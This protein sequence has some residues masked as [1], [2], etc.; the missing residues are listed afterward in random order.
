MT[1]E[2][3]LTAVYAML[4]QS[5]VTA[6]RYDPRGAFVLL[7]SIADGLGEAAP[8]IIDAVSHIH[9]VAAL[10]GCE[11]ASRDARRSMAR[12]VDVLEQRLEAVAS[13]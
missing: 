4:G 12:L 7:I 3:E 5:H 9:M 11:A 2:R 1:K 6:E 10:G 13:S 8:G